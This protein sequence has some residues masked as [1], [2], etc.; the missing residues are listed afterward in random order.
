MAVAA[1]PATSSQGTSPK[2]RRVRWADL[3]EHLTGYLFVLPAVLLVSMFGFFPMGYAFYLSLRRW[4]VVDRGFIG[5]ANYEKALGDYAGALIFAGGVALLLVALLVRRRMVDNK[6]SRRAYAVGLPLLVAVV[7][8]VA[9]PLGWGRMVEAGDTKFLNTIPVTVYY[10]IGSV[11]IQLGIALVLAYILFQK[12]R[13]QELFRMIFFLPYVTPVIATALVFRTIFGIR[14]TSIANR[15]LTALGW[16]AQKWLFESKPFVEVM[17]G[18]QIDGF[19]AGPSMALVAIIIFG[20]WTYVGY[21]TVIFLAGLGSISPDV[22]EAAEIDGANQW[23]LF[24]H[25]TVPL[26]SP[27]TFYLSLIGFIGT[28][29]AFNHIFVMQQPSAQDS[30]ITTSVSIF[31]TF[32]KG[33]QFGYASTQAVLLL[34]IILFLTYAQNKIFGERVFYG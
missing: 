33:S 32:Y 3:R 25:I 9:V 27:V 26:L 20:V 15:L 14:D 29:K 18:W 31:N 6:E 10:A 24:R 7:G 30:V 17:F 13:G 2:R 1:P 28:F 22:Y 34:G 23:Q 12:I 11:P 4:R 5:L 16:D 19:F 8:L 21:N